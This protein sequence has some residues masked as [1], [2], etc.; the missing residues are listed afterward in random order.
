MPSQEA[1]GDETKP[2]FLSRE[3]RSSETFLSSVMRTSNWTNATT[4]TWAVGST[5]D[6]R[7]FNFI[8]MWVDGINNIDSLK[9]SIYSRSVDGA[10]IFP[11][12]NGD[13][14]L[15]SKIINMNDVA[16]KSSI[17]TGYQLIR[18]VFDD[19]AVPADKTA[20]F[21][22]QPLDASGNPVYMGCGRKDITD[23]ETAALSNSLG[24]FWMPVD[25]SEWRRITIPETS[26][27]RIAFNVGYESPV[28]YGSFN[29][30]S[31][32]VASVPPNSPDWAI[33]G[34]AN[35]QF[36]GWVLSFP[37]KTGFNS[38]TLRHSNLTHVNQIYY[39]AVLRKNSD[40]A[41][42]SMPG[43]LAGDIQVYA[44]RV[45]PDAPDDGFYGVNYSIPNLNIPA[46]YFVMLV[47]YPRTEAGE[48]ADMGTQAHEY[49]TAGETAP[50][51]FAL[52]AF[53][54]RVTNTWQMITGTKGVAYW[55]N[56]VS[57]VGVVEQASVN[58]V[59]LS[60]TMAK[61]NALQQQVNDEGAQSVIRESSSN[62]WG[63]ATQPLAGTFSAG[64]YPFP[65]KW[66]RSMKSSYGWTVWH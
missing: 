44:G 11:G 59:T 13:K 45:H 52:G 16:I 14:L 58:E 61:L 42:T 22:V 46:G 65:M 66:I 21:V 41:S 29:G 26:L 36:Y 3:L 10:T 15:S 60:D 27:Y 2:Q 54:N 56:N 19:T 25:Q 51:G 39:R 24:G 5:S 43:T 62:K 4:S 30:E 64:R 47:V 48:T 55:L 50:S 6:G 1:V 40:V 53:I 23:S 38:I 28:N 34:S 37:D 31:V 12:A 49:S 9:I 8:E 17:A 57:F 33:T 32:S 63:Y 35:R 7:V 20:L 18:L